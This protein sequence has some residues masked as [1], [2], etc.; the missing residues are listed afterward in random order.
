MRELSQNPKVAESDPN[1]AEND[2]DVVENDSD[3]V[4]CDPFSWIAIYS[5]R[6]KIQRKVRTGVFF[7]PVPWYSDHS[8]DLTTCPSWTQAPAMVIDKSLIA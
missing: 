6:I 8:Y 5:N 4:D 2:S 3:V 7:E 1:V